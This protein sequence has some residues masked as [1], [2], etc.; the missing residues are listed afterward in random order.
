MARSRLLSLII[1]I[2]AVSLI[3]FVF[4]ENN[5]NQ[6]DELSF[7]SGNKE[8]MDKTSEEPLNAN[9]FGLQQGM[10]AP[11]FTLPLWGANNESTL[12]SFRGEIVVLN[13]WASWCPPCRDEMPDLVEFSDS[14]KDQGVKV[15]GINMSTFEKNEEAIAE[16]IEEYDV[17]YPTLLDQPIN[18]TNQR[19]VIETLYQVSSI[20]A[21]YILDKEGKISLPIR[22]R[23]NYDTLETE[24][25]KL[26][27]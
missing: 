7:L 18:Q 3:I 8:Q 21:T 15:V 22:G 13:L 26:L 10:Y 19:G 6:D 9:E 23:V 16:F 14:Y 2:V 11:D 4:I 20:P 25:K 1:F 24:V 17:T 12:S 27:Q 5:Q